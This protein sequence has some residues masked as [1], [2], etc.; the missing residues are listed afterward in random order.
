M[1]AAGYVRNWLAV[2]AKASFDRL[3]QSGL[4]D[5]V[6]QPLLAKYPSLGMQVRRKR[7]PAYDAQRRTN[8]VSRAGFN[9]HHRQRTKPISWFTFDCGRSGSKDGIELASAV[10]I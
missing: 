1:P 10:G 5:S 6:I 7:R 8:G 4:T 2:L 9:H 3:G